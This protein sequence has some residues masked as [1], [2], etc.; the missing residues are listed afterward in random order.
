MAILKTGNLWT[1][2]IFFGPY[3]N[4][5]YADMALSD[6]SGYNFS[7]CDLTGSSLNFALLSET[8]IKNTILKY[9]DMKALISEILFQMKPTFLILWDTLEQRAL[10]YCQIIKY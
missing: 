2:S 3:I 5:K 1:T 9:V 4:L 10:G 8:N 7:H 6:L